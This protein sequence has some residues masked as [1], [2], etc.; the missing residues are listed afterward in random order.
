MAL[1]EP[2]RLLQVV[3]FKNAGKTMLLE[4]LVRELSNIGFLVST[5]KHHGHGGEPEG[6]YDSDRL[7]RAG[8]QLSLVEGEGTVQLRANRKEWTLTNLIQM[9]RSFIQSEIV[10]IEGWKNAEFP[11]VVMLKSNADAHLLQLKNVL[12][13]IVH[14]DVHVETNVPT[15]GLTDN[16]TYVPFLIEQVKESEAKSFV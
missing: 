6:E 16:E 5:L 13:V 3:G 8:A 12:A 9:E 10:L 2:C 11:K 1:G 7:S 4:R 15:F 14:D